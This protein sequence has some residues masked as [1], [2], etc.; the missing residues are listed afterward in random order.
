[1][2]ALVLKQSTSAHSTDRIRVRDDYPVPDP[3]AGESL[4]RV[5]MAGICG[6][7]LEMLQGYM[8]FDGVPGHE[9]VGEVVRTSNPELAGRRVVGEINAA[10]GRCAWCDAGMGRHCP[11]RSVLGILGRDGAFAEYLRLPDANLIP[12]SDTLS[13]EAA[14]FAEPLAAA[15]EIF[16]Q[17]QIAPSDR[18]AILGDG[19]LGAITAIAMKARG[20]NPLLGGH[21]DAKLGRLAELGI[22]ARQESGLRPGFDVVV[23]C[24]GSAHGLSR[25]LELV[26]PRGKL[27]LKTTVAGSAGIN[28]APVVINEIQV[29][30]S[31]CGRMLPAVQALESASVDPTPL[32]SATYPL[33]EAIAAL[34]RASERSVFK[35]LLKAF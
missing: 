6:T 16:E 28:L 2:R 8:G 26:R 17:T 31:R 24:T 9:F 35:I 32:I 11:N 13:E 27:V 10:C 15:F 14:V 3:P 25:A 19:R 29:I 1:M 12:I 7:D 20:L 23:D 30:G 22:E 21:H 34:A 5:R 33:A 4:V 18:I